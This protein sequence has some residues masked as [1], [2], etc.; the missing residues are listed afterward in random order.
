VPLQNPYRNTLFAIAQISGFW[1]GGGGGPPLAKSP[2]AHLSIES[3]NPEHSFQHDEAMI[4]ST[5]YSSIHRGGTR[6]G[7]R[8][9]PEESGMWGASVWVLSH[10]PQT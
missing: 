2:E 6:L 3:G 10:L 7:S 9:A 1:G 5:S 8:S 4:F